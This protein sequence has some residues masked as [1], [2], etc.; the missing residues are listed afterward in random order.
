MVKSCKGHVPLDTLHLLVA[1]MA[2]GTDIGDGNGAAGLLT[3][4]RMT[5]HWL[6]HVFADGA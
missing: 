6:R 3:S 1:V 2:H 5:F 4:A